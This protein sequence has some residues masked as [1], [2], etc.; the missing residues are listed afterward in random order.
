MSWGAAGGRAG[1]RPGRDRRELQEPVEVHLALELD[2]DAVDVDA[3]GRRL[4]RVGA[5]AAGTQRGH[6]RL[7]R[8]RAAAVAAHRR[9]VVAGQC[10]AALD[11]L[12]ELV[13][14][15]ESGVAGE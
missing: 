4:G 15:L 1:G 12:P 3:A 11:A 6:E 5:G 13:D 7:D 8:P 9:R 2:V 10:E 14:G